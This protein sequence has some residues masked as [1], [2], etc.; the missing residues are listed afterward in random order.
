MLVFREVEEMGAIKCIGNFG[1]DLLVYVVVPHTIS[2]HFSMVPV[3]V[4]QWICLYLTPLTYANMIWSMGSII[5]IF[6]IRL[7]FQN[8]VLFLSFVTAIPLTIAAVRF[9]LTFER[10]P[11]CVPALLQSQSRVLDLRSPIPI[12]RMGHFSPSHLSPVGLSRSPYPSPCTPAE[13][14]MA[15]GG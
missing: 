4:S 15:S 3:V 9:Y 2:R 13:R 8:T 11:S 7:G 6:F 1:R 12:S 14:T 10:S 5:L